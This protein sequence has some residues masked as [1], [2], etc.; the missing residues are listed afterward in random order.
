[1]MKVVRAKLHGI[2]VTGAD[3]NYHG[4]IT[5]DPEQCEQAGIYPMEFV[6]IW[7]KQSGARIST[8]VIYGEAGSKC[9]I[10]N[11]A[12][13]RTCQKGDEVIICSADYI[14]PKELYD[15]KPRILTYLPDNSVD[16]VLQYDVFASESR[17]YDFRII[18]A[19]TQEV[20]AC[21]T[22]PNVD[23]TNIR[24]D[25]KAKGLNDEDV[26]SF[27]EKYLMR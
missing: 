21:N 2:R 13:A 14:K 11:G 22:Y 24:A 16:Q 15:L 25:L 1:M 8:Y 23:I 12:A 18:D 10:L 26:A 3:L 27:V 6:D 17:P 4:S 7:N 20:E 19:D 5:L 9:C